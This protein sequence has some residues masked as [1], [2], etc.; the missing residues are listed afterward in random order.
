MTL[1]RGFFDLQIQF[2]ENAARVKGISFAEALRNSTCLHRRFGLPALFNENHV[3]W[4]QF[5]AAIR[6]SEFPANVAYEFYLRH[7][8]PRKPTGNCFSYDVDANSK[9]VHI[10][11]ANNDDD[12]RGP[13]CDARRDMRLTELRSMYADI[14]SK[15]PEVTTVRGSSW[16]YG[17][18]QYRRLFPPQY[19][20]SVQTHRPNTKSMSVWGQFVDRNGQVR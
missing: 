12:E 6:T 18:E 1:S 11:F 19:I 20:A 16:L 13:L 15:H 17:L 14:R 7:A 10:H 4:A 3:V 9:T 2:A 8:P 5:I